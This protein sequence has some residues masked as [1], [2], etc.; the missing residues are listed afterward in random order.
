M[1][2]KKK[3]LWPLTFLKYWSGPSFGHLCGPEISGRDSKRNW[4]R[5]E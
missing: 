5:F 2:I 4:E 3:I 1:D